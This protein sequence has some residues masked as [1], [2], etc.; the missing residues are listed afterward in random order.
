MPVTVA[1]TLAG[2]V[3]VVLSSESVGVP[4]VRLATVKARVAVPSL[5]ELSSWCTSTLRSP[6]GRTAPTSHDQTPPEASTSRASK[7]AESL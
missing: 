7:S 5:P 1:R 6:T 4:G 3:P 2:S